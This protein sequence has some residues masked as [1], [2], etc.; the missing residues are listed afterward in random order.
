[1]RVTDRLKYETYKTN[2]ASIKQNM[3]TVQEK[4]A[5]QK[6]I[7]HP[8]DNP[9]AFAKDVE[10]EAEKSQNSQ[11]KSNLDQLNMVG[12]MYETSFNTVH[13]LLTKA[14][15]IAV[16]MASDTADANMRTASSEEIKGIMEQL[17][18]IG[19]TKTGNT[20]IFGGK[21]A[22]AAPFT[23]NQ[24]DYSVTFSGSADVSSVYINRGETEKMGMSGATAFYR[25]DGT[26]I[27]SALKELKN[28][29]ETNNQ[30][31]IQVSVDGVENSLQ[32]AE[33]NIAYVGAYTGKMTSLMDTN[34]TKENTLTQS[35]SDLMD[36]DMAQLVSELNMLSDAYQ[37]S[38]Y[39]M[40][41][42][43]SLSILDY[44]R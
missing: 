26:S 39:S 22:N 25:A 36:A 44:L 42:I 30:T 10:I 37:S 43:Q 27:F 3:N 24:G 15:E 35:A 6:K 41:K 17:V 5:A 34:A 12:S 18:S 16:S 2:L 32:L 9:V 33:N 1:M 31:A 29:L 23:L 4:I 8:S 19:N 11:Y 21:K 20:Y 13:D 28:A 7:L 40:S 38:L 14:K